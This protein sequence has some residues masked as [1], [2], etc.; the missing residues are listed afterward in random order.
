MIRGA[1]LSYCGHYRYTLLRCW[2]A[3]KPTLMFIMLNPS[4][5][6]A[7]HD[8]PT[9][10]RCIEF[11]K[12]WGYG[13]LLVGNLFAWR[14]PNR[15]ELR[16]VNDPIG[17]DNDHHLLRMARKAELIIAAWGNDGSLHN[18]AHAMRRLFP[19][20]LHALRITGSG[21]PGHPLYLPE[22]SK[23]FLLE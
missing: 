13:E 9:I 18:R 10:T 4:T 5:A 8:D 20:R 3:D 21:Q 12:I 14:T 16:S 22:T 23:P 7:S 11:A 2:D 1:E 6:D 15:H 19:G 17:K